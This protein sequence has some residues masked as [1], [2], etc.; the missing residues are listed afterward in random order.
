LAERLCP[1]CQ[2]ERQPIGQEV[3]EQLDFKP[4]SLFVVEHVR[5]T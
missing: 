1:Q 5:V 3:S 4:A 2:H